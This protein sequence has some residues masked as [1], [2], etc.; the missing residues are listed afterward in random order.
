MGC[1][2]VGGDK[3]PGA[4]NSQVLQ[5]SFCYY[6]GTMRLRM[7]EM[8][9]DMM[10]CYALKSPK[11]GRAVLWGPPGKGAGLV[12]RWQSVCGRDTMSQSLCYGWER[13]GKW[14]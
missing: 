14:V 3:E 2:W 6:L 12:R 4:I 13:Q 1:S 7:L 11:Q 5:C 10:L 9:F 8:M